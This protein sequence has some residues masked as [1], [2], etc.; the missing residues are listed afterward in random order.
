MKWH[1]LISIFLIGQMTI[2]C[3]T[4]AKHLILGITGVD[5]PNERVI[6]T[7]VEGQILDAG[8]PV[9]NVEVTR[10]IYVLEW[11]SSTSQKAVTDE[12]GVF[13]WD[14]L[15]TT[16]LRRGIGKMHFNHEYSVVLEDQKKIFWI[17]SKYGENNAEELFSTGDPNM[18]SGKEF[19]KIEGDRLSFVVD[20]ADL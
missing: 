4:A 3:K 8:S 1:L 19:F 7:Q 16:D 10:K 14:K 17:G 2:G 9:A 12:N 18:P 20:L 5:A 13:V 6:A 15:I 11:K